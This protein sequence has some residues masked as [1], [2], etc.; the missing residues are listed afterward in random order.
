MSLWTEIYR[1][2]KSWNQRHHNYE[3]CS[4]FYQFHS[5]LI[6][7]PKIYKNYSPSFITIF[8]RTPFCMVGRKNYDPI[9]LSCNMLI[10]YKDVVRICRIFIDH[11]ILCITRNLI[12]TAGQTPSQWRTFIKMSVPGIREQNNECRCSCHHIN[13]R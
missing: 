5:A 2:L 3:V 7:S 4:V 12:S 9:V 1:R 6:L 10:S 11:V 13:D 8:K